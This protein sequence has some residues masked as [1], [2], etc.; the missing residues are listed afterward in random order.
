MLW[1]LKYGHYPIALSLLSLGA[2]MGTPQ[3][4]VAEWTLP[5]YCLRKPNDGA[6]DPLEKLMERGIDIDVS[7]GATDADVKLDSAELNYDGS[8]LL[9]AAA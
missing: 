5:H 4:S 2:N 3:A 6:K 9:F 8:P 7:I 1:S